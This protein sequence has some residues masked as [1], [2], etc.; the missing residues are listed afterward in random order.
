MSES[1]LFA[2]FLLVLTGTSLLGACFL[3]RPFVFIIVLIVT[4]T[5]VLLIVV[6]VA[7]A[8]ITLLLDNAQVVLQSVGH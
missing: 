4:G 3:R 8:V 6:P 2:L 5:D 7:I 1:L